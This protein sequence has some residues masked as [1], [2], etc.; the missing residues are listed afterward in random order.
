MSS[1]TNLSYKRAAHILT[2]VCGLL[3][4]IFSFV[5]LF[6]FQKDVLEALHYSL[7]QGKTHYSPLI[8]A[9]I[10]TIV[11]LVFRWG[12]N[13]LLGLKGLVRAFSYFPSCLL[14]GVLTD[15][16]STIFHGRN[17]ADKW[18]WLLPLLLLT[19]IGLSYTLRRVFRHWIDQEGS[20]LRLINFNLTILL[21]LCLMTVYIGNSNINFH[22]ELAIE[23]AI[24]EK[25]YTTALNV[26]GK[27]LEA[28][29]TLTVL[30]MLALSL[31][32]TVG[33][34]LFEFPQYYGADGLLFERYS[35][36]TLRLTADSLYDYLGEKR[37]LNEATV[38]FLERI[39]HDETGKHTA[40]DYY[41]SALL[42]DKKLN[43]FATVAKD[44]FF[45]QDTMPRYYR[46]AL[47]LYKQLHPEFTR[48][49]ND[50]LMKRRF[51]EFILQQKE[52]A[53]PIKE[54]NQ[55][56]RAFGDTYWWYY[57]YQ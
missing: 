29:H 5:Y 53:S 9:I 34:Q 13:S 30:R 21:L 46:E 20:V 42:L 43:K 55:M 18:L 51:E 50:S 47:L 57:Y 32:G 37:Y 7:S 22:H 1:N 23:K 2:V 10:I 11:L 26:G 14:L 19:F 3:F 36:E 52:F 8:G 54:K 15:V 48:E 41:L 25:N 27:S 17:F 33:E 45:E 12:I 44:Y 28:S 24:Y 35:T 38:D 6:I 39:C 40:L 16:D 31:R 49:V 4:S 56:R